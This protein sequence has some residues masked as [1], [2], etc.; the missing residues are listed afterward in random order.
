M[1]RTSVLGWAPLL[2]LALGSACGKA[3]V[4]HDASVSA[5]TSTTM[6]DAGY[7]DL[8]QFCSDEHAYRCA[9]DLAAGRIDMAQYSTC[10]SGITTTC[11]SFTLP[12]ALRTDLA[13]A[14][15][16]TLAMTMRLDTPFEGIVECHVDVLCPP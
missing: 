16:D 14:C 15:I 11:E 10:V 7:A 3:V 2:S 12:C 6:A 5:D 8:V 4:V 1:G 13:Q 9:R